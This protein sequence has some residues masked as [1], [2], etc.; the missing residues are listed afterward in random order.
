MTPAQCR[1]AR[2]ALELGVRDLAQAARVSTN[3]ITRL[4]KGEALQPRTVAAIQAALETA[5][6]EFIA[7]NGGGPGVRLASP[8]TGMSPVGRLTSPAATEPRSVGPEDEARGGHE[9][10]APGPGPTVP[11]TGPQRRRKPHA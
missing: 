5:G 7:E 2:A 4:E 8:G 6:V 9:A 3:T 11:G 10:P 1:M